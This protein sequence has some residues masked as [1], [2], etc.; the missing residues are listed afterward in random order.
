MNDNQKPEESLP[1]KVV[2]GGKVWD[3][4]VLVKFNATHMLSQEI[5]Q[6][7]SKDHRDQYLQKKFFKF[8]K[9]I[10]KLNEFVIDTKMDPK[11]H[12]IEIRYL[13]QWAVN[14]V[15]R[16]HMEQN[17]ARITHTYFLV[18]GMIQKKEAIP[19]IVKVYKL[20]RKKYYQVIPS[21]ISGFDPTRDVYI[22]FINHNTCEVLRLDDSPLLRC[23]IDF[24]K[25]AYVRI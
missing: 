15:C 5:K 3:V 24:S 23:G 8:D 25:G 14:E 6:I 17:M 19:K 12:L 9:N 4:D 7:I 22:S 21:L 20:G 16:K 2:I 18:K 1:D 11:Y 13:P 10:K